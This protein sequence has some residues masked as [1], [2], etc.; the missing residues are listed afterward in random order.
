[1][2]C[3]SKVM[4]TGAGPR[5]DE[6]LKLGI[7]QGLGQGLEQELVMGHGRGRGLDQGLEHGLG[8]RWDRVQLGAPPFRSRERVGAVT[9]A[10]EGSRIMFPC[11]SIALGRQAFQSS[12]SPLHPRRICQV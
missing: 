4:R 11:A 8:R 1:V 6:E 5:V 2:V 10:V 3:S 7:G 9:V 12:F